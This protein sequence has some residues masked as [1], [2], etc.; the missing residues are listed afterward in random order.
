MRQLFKNLVVLVLFLLSAA[1]LRAQLDPTFGTNGR[2]FAD[3]AQRDVP[4]KILQKPGGK[5]L[6][7][8]EGEV[9]QIPASF[10]S[11]Y[12]ENG[13]PDTSFGNN[14]TLQIVDAANPNRRFLIKDAVIQPD[15]KTV[16]VGSFLD[17]G[18]THSFLARLNANGSI[19]TSFGNAGFQYPLMSPTS[20]DFIA[21]VMLLPDGR[22]SA[23]GKGGANLN[24]FFFIQYQ[25]NGTLDTTFNGQGYVYSASNPEVDKFFRQ[26]NG[27]F[28]VS[29]QLS[30]GAPPVL[31]RF[32][33]DGSPDNTFSTVN[34]P[35]SD[36]SRVFV[37]SD[38]KIYVVSN[39]IND[40]PNGGHL[41][42][43]RRKD[44]A[45]YRY[46]ANGV[47]DNAFGTNGKT[48]FG[49]AGYFDNVP[50]GMTVKSNGQIIVGT[51]AA[52][53]NTNRRNIFG[54]KFGIAK[55]ESNGTVSGRFL[56]TD[57]NS[58]EW[59]PYQ[60]SGKLTLLNDGK[61]LSVFANETSP[62]TSNLVISRL[63]DVQPIRYNVRISPFAAQ[64]NI[65]Y[66]SVF[67]PGAGAFYYMNGPSVFF[68]NSTDIPVPGDYFAG[69][70]HSAVF[71]PSSG[72]WYLCNT[73]GE[74]RWGTNGD[75][76]VYTGDFDGDSRADFTTFRPSNGIWSIY[77]SE[78][79]TN[80]FLQWEQ[81]AI[82]PC[83]AI[84]TVTAETT[85]RF[86]VR[87]MAFGIS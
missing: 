44:V 76:P 86:T 59:Q 52:I 17:V 48:K 13:T 15:D 54:R 3:L 34:L 6:V 50:F 77:N 45:V 2:V 80:T 78:S 33:A 10:L 85:S 28:I 38:D 18:P 9:N 26:S 35:T 56:M 51:E 49:M 39:E 11:Q 55:L 65:A 74:F 40:Y 69:L 41:L 60:V 58:V 30:A 63:T 64:G 37:A 87:Q 32:N 81:T 24:S 31:K 4:V 57:L 71:R 8:S 1:S 62:T 5:I 7:V 36:Y 14:G 61:I 23:A 67:R 73:C 19:D 75:I 20:Y 21:Y 82:N 72:T 79:G 47:S 12:N 22:I 43:N 16:V 66:P 70:S 68:G 42:T 53:Q 84:T 83:R 46:S 29:S 27:K 25:P